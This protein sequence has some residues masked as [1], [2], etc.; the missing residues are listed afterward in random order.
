MTRSNFLTL[1][2]TTSVAIGLFQYFGIYFSL[3]W[4]IPWFDIFMHILGGAWIALITYI[5][6]SYTANENGATNPPLVLCIIMTVILIGVLWEWYE[7][8]NGLTH[9]EINYFRD[10]L[11]DLIFDI[12]GA[13]AV[14]LFVSK[15]INLK[16]A[17]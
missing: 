1:F 10:T 8:T 2:L 9:S 16:K 15:K 11:S 17:I 5:F 13:S 14:Y 3:Y 6:Y 4:L 7:L 12:I